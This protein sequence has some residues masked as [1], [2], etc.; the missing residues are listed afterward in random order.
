M[1]PV[2]P[3]TIRPRVLRGETGRP[4]ELAID[5]TWATAGTP[6]RTGSLR[7][8]RSLHRVTGTVTV[9]DCT[10]QSKPFRST[11][12]LQRGSRL[13][14]HGLGVERTAPR[15]RHAPARRRPPNPRYA[16]AQ[17]WVTSSAKANRHR[18]DDRRRGG[19]I[20]RRRTAADDHHR[21]S[22]GSGQRQDRHT[23]SRAG[24]A[25]VAGRPGQ[26]VP[27]GMGNGRNRRRPARRRAGWSGTATSDW[28]LRSPNRRP[29]RRDATHRGGRGI[30]PPATT[31]R[32]SGVNAPN[33]RSIS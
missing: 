16:T 19:D 32:V 23:W 1:A 33:N 4:T 28:R 27:Q 18:D 8:T 26:P 17:R 15:R 2:R 3:S 11:R 9:G 22:A 25:G 30:S 6:Y 5:L 29:A 12:P 21:L 24:S 20:R 14:G 7:A 31:R 13:V 10:Y